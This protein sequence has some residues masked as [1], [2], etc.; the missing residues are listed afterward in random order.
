LL[1]LNASIEAAHAGEHGKGFAVVAN[2]VSNLAERVNKSARQIEE[3][4]AQIRLLTEQAVRRMSDATSTVDAGVVKVDS[5]FRGLNEMMGLVKEIGEREKEQAAVSDNIARNME[6]I[7]MLVREGLSA[8]EQTVS[9][10]DR[11][12]RLGEALLASVEQFK[13]EE[14]ATAGAPRP[15]A[16][17]PANPRRA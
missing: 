9:E 1:A 8:S 6:D 3:Q 14:S 5:T 7:F 15:K 10:G 2:E 13:T 17:P 11:L 4:L 12:K 16:L